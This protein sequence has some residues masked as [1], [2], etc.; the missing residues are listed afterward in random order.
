MLSVPGHCASSHA[1]AQE[2]A[3]AARGSV[4]T[5]SDGVEP[6]LRDANVKNDRRPRIHQPDKRRPWVCRP[7]ALEQHLCTENVS[8]K[9]QGGVSCRWCHKSVL[10]LLAALL[11]SLRNHS[12][13]SQS[14][15]PA[16]QN[17]YTS[18]PPSPSMNGACSE[19]G[20]VCMKVASLPQTGSLQ[21]LP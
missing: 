8:M 16:F 7:R 3:A 18:L 9:F 20:A 17:T 11:G 12:A 1:A 2:L 14:R 5:T 21:G 10:E 4:E 15:K 6:E 19:S 13:E